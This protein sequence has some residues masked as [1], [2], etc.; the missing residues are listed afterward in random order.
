MKTKTDV[1]TYT[2]N[3]YENDKHLNLASFTSGEV[4]GKWG[5]GEPSIVSVLCSLK[6]IKCEESLGLLKPSDGH[7][8]ILI[9]LVFNNKN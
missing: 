9:C 8:Y 7:S 6:Y 3:M 2:K 4:G 5:W 1:Y